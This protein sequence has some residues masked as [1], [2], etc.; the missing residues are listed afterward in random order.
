MAG[1]LAAP[2]PRALV[3]VAGIAA[4]AVVAP[5]VHAKDSA[6]AGVG[7]DRRRRARARHRVAGRDRDADRGVRP[8]A[9]EP[10]ASVGPA[11]AGGPRVVVGKPSTPTAAGLFAITWAIR[12]HPHD[13]LGSWVLEL[14]AHS[15][16]LHQFDG[17]DGTVGIHGRGGASLNDPLGTARSHGCI[18]LANTA[19]DWLVRRIGQSRLPAT[20]VQIR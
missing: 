19:I 3:V 17:G 16:V 20:P 5:V 12:R 15:D 6:C 8:L 14:T 11:H 7:R 1:R 18:R 10:L 9:H 4:S 2:P 13:F